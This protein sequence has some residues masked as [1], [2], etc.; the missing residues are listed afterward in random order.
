MIAYAILFLPLALVSVRAALA[1]VPRGLEEAARSLGSGWFDVAARV[2]MPLTGPGLGAGA[3]MVFVFV[4]TELTATLL[5]APIG[6]RTLAT[7]VW[8]NTSSLAFAA[9]APF[10]AMM[11]VISLLSTWLLARRFGAAVFPGQN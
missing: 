6:T 11:L 8:A 10:A 2:L 5:L 3:A 4:S 9:A 1:Q 7:E